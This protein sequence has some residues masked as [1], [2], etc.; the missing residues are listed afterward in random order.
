MFLDSKRPVHAGPE[1][2]TRGGVFDGPVIGPVE[3]LGE[4][5]VTAERA[6]QDRKQR[7]RDRQG[8]GDVEGREDPKRASQIKAPEANFSMFLE[9]DPQQRR[10]QETRKEEEHRNAEPAGDDVAEAGVPGE[11]DGERHGAN[12]I[13]RWDIELP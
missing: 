2:L 3:N 4:C 7:Q 1:R 9:L 8:K 11:D 10:D 6:G 5:R 12:P 13:E